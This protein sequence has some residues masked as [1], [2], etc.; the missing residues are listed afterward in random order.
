MTPGRG[1]PAPPKPID[2]AS[3]RDGHAHHHV[4]H[5]PD[6]YGDCCSCSQGGHAAC[7]PYRLAAELAASRE[8]A[9]RLRELNRKVRTQRN[10]L[11]NEVDRLTAELA[12]A[13][14]REQRV[15]KACDDLQRRGIEG[16]SLSGWDAAD[17]IRAA[18]SSEGAAAIT[19]HADRSLPPELAEALADLA[20]ATVESA[21]LEQTSYAVLVCAQGVIGCRSIGS[22]REHD[23]AERPFLRAEQDGH[24][25]AQTVT[26]REG[27]AD[28]P[29][30]PR[31]RVYTDP[32]DQPLY[33]R[34]GRQIGGGE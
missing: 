27:A 9:G 10:T 21:G 29:Q 33:D 4:S 18:L 32:T 7:D 14:V 2:P 8:A 23:L 31:A 19:V 13:R 17:L 15:R 22:H 25:D 6:D 1:E 28:E 11:I 12:A 3:I 26:F 5:L 16:V 30:R 24:S 34:A 20:R